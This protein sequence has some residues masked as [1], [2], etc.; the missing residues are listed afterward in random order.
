MRE[1]HFGVCKIDIYQ[2]LNNLFAEAAM[3]VEVGKNDNCRPWQEG[4]EDSRVLRG[5]C[6]PDSNEDSVILLAA[7]PSLRPAASQALPAHTYLLHGKQQEW[8]FS[9]A[10][11]LMLLEGVREDPS[12]VFESLWDPSWQKC[13][14]LLSSDRTADISLGQWYGVDSGM[15]QGVAMVCGSWQGRCM[16]FQS[17]EAWQ[18]DQR[19]GPP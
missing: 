6:K 9:E 1:K 10:I 19:T 15:R 18:Q 7:T 8:G 13:I 17:R 12:S 11:V 2:N 3:A 4:R 5:Q 14:C 16:F